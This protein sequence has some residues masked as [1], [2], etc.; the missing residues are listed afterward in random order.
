MANRLKPIMPSLREK[1][2]YIAFEVISKNP[3][4]DYLEVY[5][6]IFNSSLELFGTMETSKSGLK[7]IK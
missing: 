6:A 2:R 1:K 4:K 5:N 3:V 7:P